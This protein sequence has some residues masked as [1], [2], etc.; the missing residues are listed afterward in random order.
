MKEKTNRFGICEWY[1]TTSGASSILTAGA[2]GLDGIQLT[3]LGGAAHNFPLLD[4]A[5]QAQYLKASAETGVALHSLHTFTLARDSG[6]RSPLNSPQGEAAVHSFKQGLKACNALHIPVILVASV[7]ATGSSIRNDWDMENTGKMLKH[8]VQLAKDSGVQLTYEAA[9]TSSQRT[10]WL[11]DYAGDGLKLCYDTLNPIRF[12]N[13]DPL[14]EIPQFGIER[15]DHIHV[16]DAPADMTGCCLVGEGAGKVPA[17]INLAKK[18][19]YEGWYFLEN[20]YYLP[21]MNQKGFGT[22]LIK[23]DLLTLKQMV[24]G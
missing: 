18:L 14:I 19:G 11:L 9:L 15:I 13:A 4:P 24:E 5:I 6:M 23:K 12:G 17:I 1:M 7:D 16:K 3:D 20:Y 2:L 22:E 10:K 21:P 8:F